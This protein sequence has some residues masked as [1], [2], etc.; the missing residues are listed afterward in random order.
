[1]PNSIY[2]KFA[3]NI[4]LRYMSGGLSKYADSVPQCFCVYNVNNKNHS[5]EEDSLTIL[6][7]RK[8]PE[9]QTQLLEP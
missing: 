5:F 7:I 9:E 8:I 1:M 4:F 3:N 2:V 6:F